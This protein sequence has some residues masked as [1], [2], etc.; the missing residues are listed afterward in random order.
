VINLEDKPDNAIDRFK[1]VL[2]R[3]PTKSAFVRTNNFSFINFIVHSLSL[4]WQL[5]IIS[6]RLPSY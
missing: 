2:T 1:Q 4:R 3:G 5:G 6:T